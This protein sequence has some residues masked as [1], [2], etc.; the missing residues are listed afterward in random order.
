MLKRAESTPRVREDNA[1]TPLSGRKT[2]ALEKPVCAA[3]SSRYVILLL[4][5]P[6][7]HVHLGRDPPVLVLVGVENPLFPPPLFGEKLF[8]EPLFGDS[9]SLPT[10]ALFMP[11]KPCSSLWP[12]TCP[13]YPSTPRPGLAGYPGSTCGAVTLRHS[14]CGGGW[15]I[16]LVTLSLAWANV[17]PTRP[18]VFGQWPQYPRAA[19]A[20]R[21]WLG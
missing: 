12:G 21:P 4:S 13:V 2:V 19:T 6:Q 8:G 11:T 9:R 17:A 3:P 1:N 18:L 5:R 7:C 16:S 10:A 14:L 15:R 20:A